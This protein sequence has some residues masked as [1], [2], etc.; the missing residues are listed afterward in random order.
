MLTRAVV[1]LAWLA[2]SVR[3][4]CGTNDWTG[5]DFDAPDGGLVMHDARGNATDTPFPG[6]SVRWTSIGTYRGQR[7]DL[8]VT[9]RTGQFTYVT[10]ADSN[11]N[12]DAAA[13]HAGFA[14]LGVGI[15]PASM[16]RCAGGG[17][18]SA[19]SGRCL[20][21]SNMIVGGAEFEMTF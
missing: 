1:A 7:F 2:A 10:S 14:C 4:Q 3:A 15:A 11:H 18:A 21:A 17:T 19:P 12:V 6:G 16:L 13:R 5:V 20:G 8:L 9:L